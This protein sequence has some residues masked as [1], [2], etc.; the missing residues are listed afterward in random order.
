MLSGEM[1]IRVEDS[2]QSVSLG[3]TEDLLTSLGNSSN[4]RSINACFSV[5]KAQRT[6][7]FITL[8]EDK[9]KKEGLIIKLR[10]ITETCKFSGVSFCG[11][12]FKQMTLW[13]SSLPASSQ[14]HRLAQ[15]NLLPLACLHLCLSP[16]ETPSCAYSGH[17]GKHFTYSAP[18]PRHIILS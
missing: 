16:K 10:S 12:Y 8:Q 4:K 15:H 6:K 7:N 1:I 9:K 5:R 2:A 3:L 17:H 13:A 14:E 18:L 11:W